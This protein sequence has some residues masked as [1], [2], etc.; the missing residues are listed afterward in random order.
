MAPNPPESASQ[1]DARAELAAFA[2]YRSIVDDWEAFGAALA[3]PLPICVW[4]NTL[5]T[6]PARL[7]EWMARGGFP[8]APIGWYPGAFRL[9]AEDARGEKLRPGNR[10]EY[11]AGLYHIQEEVSLIPPVLLAA[12]GDER[13]LDLC[14]APGN[15]TAQLAVAM[16]NRGTL[17][18]NDRDPYRISG[19]RRTLERLG[20]TNTSVTVHDGANYPA[21]HYGDT[22]GAFDKVLVDAPCSC[23]G[24]SRKHQGATPISSAEG[25][26][27]LHGT[28][29]ALLRKAVQLCKVGGRIVY[30]TCTYAPEENEVLVDE[31]LNLVGRAHLRLLP[32]RIPGLITSAGLTHWAGQDLGEDLAQTLRVWPHQNNTGGFFAALIEKTAETR[33]S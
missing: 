1:N 27:P 15:K 19:L 12:T 26:A 23:E 24:T 14:A 25:S 31:L 13:V 33:L 22:H 11:L 21:R 2:R 7:G 18:A 16:Q 20:I 6:T 29:L 4:T 3:R 30:S 5:R 32:A 28:Q 9:P 17:I 10:V 8:V